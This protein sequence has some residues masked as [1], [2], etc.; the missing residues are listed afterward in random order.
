[1]RTEADRYVVFAFAL[2]SSLVTLGCG[3]AHSDTVPQP[4]NTVAVKDAANSRELTDI[5]QVDFRNFA[6]RAD[7]ACFDESRTI[8]T[9]NGEYKEFG[10]RANKLKFYLKINNVVY[11]DLTGDGSDEAIVQVSC[12]AGSYINEALIYTLRDNQPML[13]TVL[14]AG[15][16][17]LGGI[18]S[19]EVKNSLLL[20]KRYASATDAATPKYVFSET[21]RWDGNQFVE[22]AKPIRERLSKLKH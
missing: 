10:E 21:L 22:A 5:K 18:I 7:T 15:H 4:T 9:Q 14:D 17:A 1:M 16:R 19:L 13:L 20:V 12:D 2:V 6:Y 11:G 3:V 8:N